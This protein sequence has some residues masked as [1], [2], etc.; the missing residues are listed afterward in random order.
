MPLPRSEGRKATRRCELSKFTIP[1]TQWKR[2][3][4]GLGC[5]ALSATVILAAVWKVFKLQQRFGF[6]QTLEEANEFS[7]TP[8]VDR[9]PK[10]FS[11][12]YGHQEHC[13]GLSLP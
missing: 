4:N 6:P 12:P 1:S 8:R 13:T 7:T 11:G 5:S 2:L 3:R 9:F 10:V